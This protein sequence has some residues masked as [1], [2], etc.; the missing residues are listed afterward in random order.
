MRSTR[1]GFLGA[2]AGLPLIGKFVK[3][4]PDHVDGAGVIGGI[5]ESPGKPR[6]QTRQTVLL[7]WKDGRWERFSEVL[8]LKSRIYVA[9]RVSKPQ[10]VIWESYDEQLVPVDHS[11][12]QVVFE[13]RKGRVAL[14]DGKVRGWVEAEERWAEQPGVPIYQEV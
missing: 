13:R 2:L 14:F 12:E 6:E 3:A 5:I 9:Q 4:E 11:L 8:P 7:F 1:R 10:N